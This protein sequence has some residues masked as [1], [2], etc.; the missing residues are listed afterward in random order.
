[1]KIGYIDIETALDKDVDDEDDDK[2]ILEA[3]FEVVFDSLGKCIRGNVELWRT[4]LKQVKE[5]IDENNTRPSSNTKA[6]DNNE[7]QFCSWISKQLKNAKNRTQIMKEQEIYD[8]WLEFINDGK[9]SYYML[10]NNNTII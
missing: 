8:E 2:N 7:K 10:D 1:M 9:Y 5:F 4:R 6:K 3:K